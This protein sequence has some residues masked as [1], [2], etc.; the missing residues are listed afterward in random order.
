MAYDGKIMRRASQRFEEDRRRRQEEF[1]LRTEAVYRREPRLREVQ[2]E[3]N[4]TMSKL[5][6]GAL[7][8]GTDPRPAIEGLKNRNLSLQEERASLLRGLGLPPDYLEEKPSCPLCG[9]TGRRGE[10]VC[11][12]LRRYYAQEQQR[13]LSRMLDLGSQSFDT[14]SLDW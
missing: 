9:D 8:Q 4:A 6:A 14:F 13:E 1:R 2:R 5:I 3:L 12:C 7:R 10:A 11:R